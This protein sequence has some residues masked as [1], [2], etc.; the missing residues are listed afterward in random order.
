MGNSTI[1]VVDKYTSEVHVNISESTLVT[2]SP[3]NN[4]IVSEV[5]ETELLSSGQ[6][7]PA[8]PPGPSGEGAIVVIAGENLGGG[9][10][11]MHENDEAFYSSSDVT[12]DMDK[13]IGVT[14]GAVVIG[15]DS[16]VRSSGELIDSSW[17]WASGPIYNG[18]NGIMTQTVPS[19]GF[20]LQVATAL[21]P[22]KILINIK[23]GIFRS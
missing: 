11:V 18:L 12:D 8:G 20:V 9:R 5:I 16:N 13:V 1:V 23:Q 4:V 21:S 15:A 17:S 7:G 2:T 3:T 14:I 19:T 22:T 6:Q 10:I